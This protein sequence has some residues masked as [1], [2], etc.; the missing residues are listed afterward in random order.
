MPV[1]RNDGVLHLHGK[2][3][4]V[5]DGPRHA[6]HRYA[7]WQLELDGF[8]MRRHAGHEVIDGPRDLPPDRP[9]PGFSIRCFP[10]ARV[11]IAAGA[12]IAGDPEFFGAFRSG[13]EVVEA[14]CLGGDERGALGEHWLAKDLG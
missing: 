8:F 13:C 9:L 6:D 11:A 1:G 10:S 2:V 5:E 4:G 12:M 7:W 3:I 14:V